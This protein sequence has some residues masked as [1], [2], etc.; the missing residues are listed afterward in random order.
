MKKEKLKLRLENC[1]NSLEGFASEPLKKLED[2]LLYLDSLESFLVKNDF[3]YLLEK[4]KNLSVIL[5]TVK[6]FLNKSKYLDPNLMEEL[7]FFIRG[8]LMDISSHIDEIEDKD[9][10]PLK[11]I[12]W[13][14]ILFL[15]DWIMQFLKLPEPLIPVAKEQFEKFMLFSVGQDQF[16]L[17][18][19]SFKEMV[20]IENE[21]DIRKKSLVIADRKSAFGEYPNEFPK[22]M[23]IFNQKNSA[24]AL[25]IDQLG[26][27]QDLNIKEFLPIEEIAGKAYEGPIEHITIFEN[28]PL[29]ILNPLSSALRPLTT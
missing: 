16:T 15:N 26:N 13:Q 23:L 12:H 18:I 2:F 8:A 9:L 6:K 27:T 17:P 22:I 14:K 4:I 24:L 3:P 7:L 20:L 1:I 10:E 21:E 29:F 28:K 11:N 5:L 25:E 19:S